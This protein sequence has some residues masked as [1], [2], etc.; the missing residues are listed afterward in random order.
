MWQSHTQRARQIIEDVKR[1]SITEAGMLALKILMYHGRYNP[2][3]S[4]PRYMGLHEHENGVDQWHDPAFR[5]R[6]FWGQLPST[7]ARKSDASSMPRGGEL[8]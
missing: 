2:V 5:E 1:R 6:A 4:D 3:V 8:S 7:F